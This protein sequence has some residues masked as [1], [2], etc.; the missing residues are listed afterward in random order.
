MERIQSVRRLHIE[1]PDVL[2]GLVC[3]VAVFFFV[4][5]ES[6]SGWL[7]NW[8]LLGY[9]AVFASFASPAVLFARRRHRAVTFGFTAAALVAIWALPSTRKDFMRDA[10][11]LRPGMTAAE[12]RTHMGRWLTYADP[13]ALSDEGVTVIPGWKVYVGT[14]DDGY[15]DAVNLYVKQGRLVRTQVILD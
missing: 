12:V 6:M 11:Q 3:A 15:S 4:A 1:M 8:F 9:L 13:P 14:R 5:G 10:Y 2:L 7:S